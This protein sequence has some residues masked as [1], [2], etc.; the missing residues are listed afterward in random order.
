MYV[1]LAGMV[2]VAEAALVGLTV[3]N[4]EAEPMATPA[5]D[6]ETEAWL[7][8]TEATEAET[9]AWLAETD[10]TEAREELLAPVADAEAKLA[11]TE[12]EDADAL[13]EE[14]E[15]DADDALWT[16]LAMLEYAAGAEGYAEGMAT[17]VAL[18]AGTG[19]TAGMLEEVLS[20]MTVLEQGTVVV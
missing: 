2:Q 1:A 17:E 11:E 12:A 19:A 16:R 15:A 20:V 10:A 5:A 9:E 14:A 3:A 4:P 7:A 18:P 13:A 6:A 8:E